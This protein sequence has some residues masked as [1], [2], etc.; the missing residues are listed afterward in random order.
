MFECIYLKSK[1][2][3][4]LKKKK[5]KRERREEMKKNNKQVMEMK[6]NIFQTL[7]H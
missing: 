5:K 2:R 7:N 1:L 3:C 4:S 6:N